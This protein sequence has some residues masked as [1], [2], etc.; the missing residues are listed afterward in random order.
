MAMMVRAAGPCQN[1]GG[2]RAGIPWMSCQ[3]AGCPRPVPGTCLSTIQAAIPPLTSPARA[4]RGRG[5]SHGMFS[6][7]QSDEG[8]VE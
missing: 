1:V 3:L 2:Q 7:L 6:S 4:S 8:E 5:H